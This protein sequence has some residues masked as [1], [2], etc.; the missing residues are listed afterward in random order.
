M[1]EGLLSR[2]PGGPAGA[3]GVVF[4]LTHSPGGRPFRV[5]AARVVDHLQRALAPH[6]GRGLW[7]G[8]QPNLHGL[9]PRL[10]QVLDC[11]LDGESEK[12]AALRLGIHSTTVHDHVKRLYRHFG[13]GARAELLAYF[14]RRH[15]RPDPPAGPSPGPGRRVR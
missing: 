9:S 7:L 15:R 11:L 14:L 4:A 12:H 13:V 2:A 3:P 8:C 1:Y 5:R 10:R 6:Y